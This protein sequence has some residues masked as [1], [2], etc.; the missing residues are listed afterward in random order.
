MVCFIEWV[1]A[2]AKNNNNNKINGQ[3]PCLGMEYAWSQ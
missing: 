2:E 1:L 3:Q